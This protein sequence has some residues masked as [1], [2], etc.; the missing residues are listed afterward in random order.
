M[1]QVICTH[2]GLRILVPPT[3]QGKHGICFN[4]GQGLDV[5]S[6]TEIK[7]H[8]DLSYE[9]GDRVTDRYVIEEHVGKGGMGVVYRARDTLVNEVVAL[10]FL[11]PKLLRTEKGQQL[12]IQE[13]QIAR[14]LRHENIVA[15]HDVSWTAEGILFL[16]MEFA[17]GQPLR[18]FLRRQRQD[19][20][21]LDIRLAVTITSQLLRA[22][23]FAHRYVVHR[24][25]KPE[26][27]MFLPGEKVKILDFGLAKA[28]Q[29]EFIATGAS[30]P[31]REK[32]IGPL[33]Y[34]SPEQK[35]ML[36]VD[37]RSDLYAV[38]LIFH[39]LL[40]LRTPLDEPVSAEKVRPDASPSLIACLL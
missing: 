20:K 21:F 27:V 23:E 35:K 25:M 28:V 19:R 15:V 8:L 10:K 26:N 13:A 17:D 30:L 4:C 24:D 22:F 3:V 11:H 31:E 18:Q 5:P 12:F 32:V 37:L 7:K 33:A 29:E 1:I 38:G 34:A 2:C 40:T 16:S 39:E 36:G 6:N 14:R 9:P